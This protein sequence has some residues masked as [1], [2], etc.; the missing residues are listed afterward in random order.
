MSLSELTFPECEYGRTGLQQVVC[1]LRFNPI[2]KISQEPPVAFQDIVRR[3][4]PLFE[5]EDSAGFRMLQVETAAPVVEA[6][7]ANP[8]VWR[9]YSDDRRWAAG[10]SFGFL[11]LE[12]KSYGNFAEFAEKFTIL[13]VALEQTYSIDAFSR[14]GLRYINRFSP[15]DFPGGWQQRINRV[16][17]G[18]LAD[19]VVGPSV[20]AAQQRIIVAEDDWSV[21][22]THGFGDDLEYVI[23][24]DHSTESNVSAPSVTDTLS[25]FNKRVFQVFRW[26]ITDQMHE[27]MEPHER[28]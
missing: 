8:P 10:L 12:T 4:F 15:A 28:D 23:D 18:T 17:L 19:P 25:T 21:G 2:L 6:L 3:A 22:L 11:S 9:F 1:Q 24:I 20:K 16:L 26:A 13:F 5:R 7:T 27:E 14:V